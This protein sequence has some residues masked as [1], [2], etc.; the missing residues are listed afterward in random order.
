MG[1][2]AVKRAADRAPT[3]RPLSWMD[4]PP[5]PPRRTGLLSTPRQWS[6][7]APGLNGYITWRRTQMRRPSG[8]V[9]TGRMWDDMAFA[10]DSLR[11]RVAE[12]EA[13]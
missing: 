1:L 12:L 2:L 9:L 11:R 5:R 13:R 8:L 7:P 6:S 10:V 3:H 4:V